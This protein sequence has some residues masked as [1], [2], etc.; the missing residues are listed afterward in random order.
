MKTNQERID[1]LHAATKG[2]VYD[3]E[4]KYKPEVEKSKVWR[5]TVTL[6][7]DWRAN[8]LQMPPLRTAHH[9]TLESALDEIEALYRAAKH[10]HVTDLQ[11]QIRTLATRLG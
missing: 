9:E 1:V 6:K 11:D 5:W 4:I 8:E 7:P 2:S 10:K 3:F